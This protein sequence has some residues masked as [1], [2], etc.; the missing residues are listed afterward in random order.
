MRNL[1]GGARRLRALG[2][3]TQMVL[4]APVL[5]PIGCLLV[6]LR[7]PQRRSRDSRQLLWLLPVG[8]LAA[9]HAHAHVG[10]PEVLAVMSVG[11]LLRLLH[12]PRFAIACS[13]VWI[14]VLIADAGRL[15]PLGLREAAAGAAGLMLTIAAGRLWTMRHGATA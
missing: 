13:M 14:T 4:L 12:D 3:H 11:G 2:P 5:V 10:L 9:L 6:M 8:V 15:A 7:A 1:E